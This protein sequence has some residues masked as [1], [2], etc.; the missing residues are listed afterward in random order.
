MYE[1]TTGNFIV[2]NY[3]KYDF[4]IHF[5]NVEGARL[6]VYHMSSDQVT[7]ICTY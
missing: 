3:N 6:L 4:W 2:I 1:I 5:A 7:V